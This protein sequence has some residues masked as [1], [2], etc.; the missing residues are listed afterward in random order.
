[1]NRVEIAIKEGRCVLALGS[2]A[3]AQPEVQA[4]LRRRNVPAVTLGDTAVNPAVLPT[5]AALTPAT[6]Q[7][8]GLVVIVEPEPGVD[9]RGLS[10]LEQAIQ[11]GANKPRY[12]IAAKAFNPFGLPMSMRLGKLE[13]EKMRAADFLS[14]L[15]VT[16]MPAPAAAP[17]ADFVAPG[18]GPSNRKKA[19]KAPAEKLRAPLPVFVGREEELA[20]LQGMLSSDGGPVIVHGAPGAGRR[21]LVEQALA[22]AGLERLPD[23]TFARGTGFDTLIGRFAM[24]AKVAGDDRLHVALT[25]KEGPPAPVELTQLVVDVLSG[26]AMSGKVMVFHRLHD[27]QDRRDGSFYRNGRLETMLRALFQ[28][29]PKLRIVAISDI[30]LCFYREGEGVKLRQLAVAGL[31]GRE[32][33]EVFSAH[34]VPEFPRD[35]FGAIYERTHGHPVSARTFGLAVTREGDVDKVL[36]QQKF[37]KSDSITDLA[38]LERHLKRRLEKLD[39]ATRTAIT[40]ACLP[41]EPVS[42]D[43]LQALG[44]SRNARIELLAQGW[45]EQTP[46]S[47]NRLY[48]IHPLVAVHIPMRDVEDFGR[49]EQLGEHFI[50]ESRRLKEAGKLL[51]SLAAAQEGN[52][53]LV[54]ARRGRAALRLPYADTDAHI[55][56]LRGLIRRRQPRLDIAKLRIGDLKKFVSGNTELMLTEAEMLVVDNA[57]ADAISAAFEVAAASHP[58]PEVFHTLATWHQN[59]NARGK[60]AQALERGLALFPN[61]ARMHRRLAGFLM[62]LDRP[63]DAINI[64]RK[65]SDLEPMMPDTYGMLGEIYML[66]GTNRWS[67][68]EECIAEARRLA[69]ESANH[70]AREADLEQRKAMV[71]ADERE[72][73]LE[74][75]EALLREAMT[76]EKEN[77]RVLVLLAKVILDRGGDLDQAEWLLKQL[78]RREQAAPNRR[79]RREDAPTNI[80][81]ARVLVRREAFDDADRLLARVIKSE[82]TNHEAH[83]AMG[84]LMIAR[85]ELLT[86][87]N[88]YK[89]ARERVPVY[90]PEVSVYDNMLAR[91]KVL[92]ETGHA[93]LQ[94]SVDAPGEVPQAQAGTREGTTIR[95][96]RADEA[97]ADEASADEANA[98]EVV[99]EDETSVTEDEGPADDDA[100]DLTDDGDIL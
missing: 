59:R 37:L 17:S 94:E 20:E 27:L 84:E 52:R 30:P 9:G 69:P 64:L 47:E 60:A 33:H 8:G 76:F 96:R 4:E 13:Q 77:R 46:G 72:A 83:A 85:G 73:H 100:N 42:S 29:T 57:N 81:R 50:K 6:A 63:L 26:D 99:N 56:E 22:T 79:R 62:S 35:R 82:P 3:L 44:I 55:D 36:A 87:H 15:P 88:A 71:N 32:L 38:A 86:A 11:A 28:G 39:E 14:A 45:M 68:A 78:A 43:V 75:A 24:A 97:S 61:D 48:Y 53:L 21:W 89:T 23:I 98:D 93:I 34:N 58:T 80:Q 12:I 40:I 1:M 49:M 65:A 10:A 19:S 16:D 66:L 2:R 95:R 7:A 70:I 31:K 91:I 41:R 92:I 25:R 18:E 54:S 74:R 5:A 90:A 67:E 51:E